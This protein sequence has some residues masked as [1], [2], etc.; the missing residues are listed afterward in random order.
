MNSDNYHHAGGTH[1][2]EVIGIVPQI[3]LVLPFVIGLVIYFFAV[4][5]SNRRYR[6]WPFYRTVLWVIGVLCAIVAVAG[7]FAQRAH[8]D[9]TVHML[10]HLLLGMLAPLLMV[11][12]APM[13][14][15]LRTLNVTLARR[16]TRVL[17]SWPVRLLSDPI[18]ASLLNIGGL[19][20]LYATDLY[21][22]MHENITLHV[23]IH[24]HVFLA[25]YLFTLSMIYIDPTPHPTSYVYRATVLILALA[26]HGILSKYIYA[27]PPSGIPVYQAEKGGML[28]YYGGDTIDIVII[29]LLCYQWYRATR[30]KTT[31]TMSR[32]QYKHF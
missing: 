8:T 30:P 13:T 4:I 27:N 25:G 14:L 17:K 12:S 11:L 32:G 1:I 2:H 18:V 6:K 28:M 16:L 7:P 20:I 9:F 15:A 23:L 5:N 29:F 21:T 31:V 10:G 3:I 26:A 22:A 24:L 19:W